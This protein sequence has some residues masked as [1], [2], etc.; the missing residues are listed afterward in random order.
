[1]TLKARRL[2]V[3]LL[4]A[5]ALSVGPAF[6]DSL[7]PPPDLDS[8]MVVNVAPAPPDV[9]TRFGLRYWAKRVLFDKSGSCRCI[10]CGWHV[11][12]PRRIC[13]RVC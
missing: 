6:A 2:N 7:E 10:K 11:S 4:T 5:L 13:W 1:M 12:P 3:A 9:C 8:D